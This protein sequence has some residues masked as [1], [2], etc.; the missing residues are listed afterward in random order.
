MYSQDDKILEFTLH[1]TQLLLAFG[2]QLEGVMI[3][4]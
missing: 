3:Q 2:S 4:G 1:S